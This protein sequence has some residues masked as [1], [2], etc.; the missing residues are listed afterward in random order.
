[1]PS[2]EIASRSGAISLSAFYWLT[3]YQR[4]RYAAASSSASWTR[5]PSAMFTSRMCN[6]RIGFCSRLSAGRRAR[7]GHSSCGYRVLEL[8]ARVHHARGSRQ[9]AGAAKPER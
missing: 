1:M 7:A 4:R 2:W 6:P 3:G 8:D 5:F 9:V